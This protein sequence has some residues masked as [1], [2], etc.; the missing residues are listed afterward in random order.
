MTDVSNDLFALVQRLSA[1]VTTLATELDQ[2]K[3]P[4]EPL[5]SD[6]N[7]DEPLPIPE[8]ETCIVPGVKPLN[9]LAANIVASGSG[10]GVCVQ[11]IHL[12]P[13]EAIEDHKMKL[14]VSGIAS[15][16]VRDKQGVVQAVFGKGTGVKGESLE[17]GV[18][19]ISHGNTTDSIGV[20]G[21]GPVGVSGKGTGKGVEGIGNPGGAGVDGTV[22]GT[23]VR[24]D[25]VGVKG[26]CPGLGTGFAAPAK[27]AQEYQATAKA[28]REYPAQVLLESACL[29]SLIKWALTERARSTA[30]LVAV[31]RAVR[32]RLTTA[33]RLESSD[34]RWAAT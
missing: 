34:T 7:D 25:S 3:G 1:Q 13:S 33:L 19:G 11:A 23:D 27:A 30:Y 15:E 4:T 24:E 8:K 26:H 22:D 14:A 28:A 21:R 12:G 17:T 32:S 9:V 31:L 10:T 20:S 18:K 2:L 6:S 16:L 29:D 5:A